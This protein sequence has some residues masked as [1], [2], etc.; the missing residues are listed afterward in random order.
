MIESPMRRAATVCV[1]LGTDYYTARV[2]QRLSL[3]EEVRANAL[4]FTFFILAFVIEQ[5]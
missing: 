4:C 5:R 2:S 3:S 1:D